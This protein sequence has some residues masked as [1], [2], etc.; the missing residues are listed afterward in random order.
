MAV[1]HQGGVFE[2]CTTPQESNL[3]QTAF[4]ALTY[5]PVPQVVSAPS[6]TIEDNILTQNT[7]DDDIA[8]KQ[9]GFRQAQDTTIEVALISG[10]DSGH[11]ALDAA[12]RTKNAY[13]VRYILPDPVTGGGTGT[14][15]Y[16]RAVIGGGGVGGGGGEDFANRTYALGVTSQFPIEVDAT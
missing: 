3:D 11:A 9:K 16:A 2:I 4:E 10:G 8:Q 1:T 5:V 15:T 12:A 7:L 6:F 14:T 13:A